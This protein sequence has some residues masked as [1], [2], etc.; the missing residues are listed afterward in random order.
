V[1]SRSLERVGVRFRFSAALLGIVTAL[2][3]DA[4]EISSAITA[5]YGGNNVVGV[6]IVFGSNVFIYAAL[7]GLSS[8]LTGVVRSP[9]EATLFTGIV[10]LVVTLGGSL[11]ALSALPDWAGLA[12][13]AVVFFPYVATCTIGPEKLERMNF[14]PP[15]RRFLCAALREEESS[16]PAAPSA[17]TRDMLLAVPAL[18]AIIVGSVGMVNG[19]EHLGTAFGVS[20]A[21]LGA[22]VLAALTGIPNA[23]AATRLARRDQGA[24][25]VS[26]A[27]NSNMINI[28]AGIFLPALFVGIGRSGAAHSLSTYWII[29]MTIAAIVLTVRK[30]GLHRVE[31]WFLILAYCVYVISIVAFG[32]S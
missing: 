2:G 9:K 7:L 21:I 30:S 18:A 8:V 14:V 26:E 17:T 3:A 28:A 31:G 29:V 12:I 25:V 32:M 11:I 4:P 16:E 5:M 15:L 6:G 19:A 24:A 1:L 13:F 27:F 22:V 23:I 20:D 10:A